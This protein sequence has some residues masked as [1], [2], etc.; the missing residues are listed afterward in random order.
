M[1]VV[2][3]IVLGG[4]LSGYGYLVYAQEQENTFPD[5]FAQPLL[6]PDEQFAMGADWEKLQ[7]EK[8]ERYIGEDQPV[9]K[10]N[11][12]SN[13]LFDDGHWRIYNNT[14]YNL[15]DLSGVYHAE[16]N[17]AILSDLAISLGYGI[18][19]YLQEKQSIGYEYLSSFPYDRGQSVK[20]FWKWRF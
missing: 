2:L 8:L 18:E 13:N 5:F 10:K 17:Q 15:D 9:P 3:R 19:Y 14:Q 4:I 7:Q 20:L 12:L 1:R 16:I 6:K 11:F